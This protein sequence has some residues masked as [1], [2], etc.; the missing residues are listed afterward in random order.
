MTGD[1]I[2]V[3]QVD[4]ISRLNANDW[5]QLK[6]IIANKGLRV[7]ALDLPASHQFMHTSDEFTDRMLAALNNMMLDML[8]AVARKD[9]EDRRRQ[10]QGV[11]RA[12]REGKYKGRPVN[13]KL[14]QKIEGLLREGK[15]Y[16]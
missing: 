8:A 3:E 13:F 2:S 15:S 10:A 1:I 12:K 4:R 11:Q 7:V 16:S 6:N 14:H 5:E 9:Y